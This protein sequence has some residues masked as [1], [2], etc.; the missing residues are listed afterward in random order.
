MKQLSIINKTD[1]DILMPPL[2]T[3]NHLREQCYPFL[4]AL[5]KAKVKY[6][7]QSQNCRNLIADR[8]VIFAANHF[9][10][11]DIPIAL[12]A[13]GRHTY[14]LVGKQNL[15]FLDKLFF[16]LNGAIWVDRKNRKHMS[17]AK[18]YVQ[19]YLMKGYSVLWFPEGTW[20]LTENLLMLPMKWGLIDVAKDTGAQVIPVCLDYD[21]EKMICRARFGEPTVFSAS[22]DKAQAIVR[23]RDT[24][25]T[26]RWE[27]MEEH[28]VHCR[29]KLDLEVEREALH[30]SIREYPL[31]DWAYEESCIFKPNEL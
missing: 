29:K 27:Y 31:I 9:A 4:M 11:A 22:D 5:T 1:A 17:T 13:I 6:H 2:K 28:G 18:K 12:K 8:P 16:W 7:V 19:S 30:Y 26:M 25:A 21:R 15:G 10:F 20:N 23:V 3:I 24:L 14:V